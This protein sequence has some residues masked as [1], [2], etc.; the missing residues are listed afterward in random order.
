MV[1]RDLYTQ[2]TLTFD[3][4]EINIMVHDLMCCVIACN[5]SRDCV[6]ESTIGDELSLIRRAI[7]EIKLSGDGKV[8]N[9][10][11]PNQGEVMTFLGIS[12]SRQQ[13]QTKN[14]NAK[15]SKQK[16]GMNCG[17]ISVSAR[18]R[19]VVN[20][21]VNDGDVNDTEYIGNWTI[22]SINVNVHV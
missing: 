1:S 22:D 10:K 13:K 11:M 18:S 4:N 17:N 6:V 16:K 19:H 21:I 7:T 8:Q 9:K 12:N 14:K 15:K 5:D 3:I 2:I 20:S